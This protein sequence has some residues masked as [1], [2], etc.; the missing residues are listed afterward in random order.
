MSCDSLGLEK[1]SME[2]TL[3]SPTATTLTQPLAILLPKEKI[4]EEALRLGV[5]VRQRVVDVYAL[6]WTL[7]L[8]FQTGSRRSIGALHRTYRKT[9]GQRLSRSSFYDRLTPRFAMLLRTLAQ[10]AIG[11]FGTA[12]GVPPP[13]L[14]SFKELLALDSTVVRLHALLAEAYAACRTNHTKAAAKLHVVMNVLD[15][16]PHRVKLTPERVHD[17]TPWRRVGGWLKGCL[18]LFDLG[19]FSYHLF[20]R[21]DRNG[22]FF[23][24]RCKTNANPLIVAVH[25]QWRGQSIQP[26][27]RRLK[28]VLPKLHRNVL[29]V[30]VEIEFKRRAYLGRQS[31]AHRTFRL[32]AIRNEETRGYHVYLTNLSAHRLS[33]ED[34]QAVYALRWQVELLFKALKSHGRLEQLPSSNQAIVEAWL[35]A[36]IL[37]AA[38]SQALYRLIRSAVEAVRFMPLL[39]WAV[40]FAEVAA[41]LLRLVLHPVASEAYRLRQLLIHEAVDPNVNRKKRAINLSH[42]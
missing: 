14:A 12:C 20:D 21:I 34:V 6:V 1:P 38:A 31:K 32:I 7:V 10:E 16:S 24:T 28:E 35:W 26:V 8:G 29:D 13:L 41:D 9:T 2:T 30:E 25:R 18:L 42:A 39:R 19:Y 27:G 15:G 4:E 40:V 33:A 3:M 17:Q 37:A 11:S 23:L 36:S 5:V 22:G